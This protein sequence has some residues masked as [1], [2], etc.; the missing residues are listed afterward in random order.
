[1]EGLRG[2]KRKKGIGAIGRRISSSARQG[3][4]SGKGLAG[5]SGPRKKGK[6][7]R[8]ERPDRG[9]GDR[10][11]LGEAG[12]KRRTG[13]G[14]VSGGGEKEKRRKAPASKAHD[15]LKKE[16]TSSHQGGIRKNPRKRKESNTY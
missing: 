7:K 15:R 10:G 5:G 2:K 3:G 9:R 12:K 1:V 4:P 8:R 6:K 11:A 14:P 16:E 13:P